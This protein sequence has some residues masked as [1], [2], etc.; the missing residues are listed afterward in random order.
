MT[1]KQQILN[2]KPTHDM[3]LPEANAFDFA[4]R[5]AAEIAAEADAEIA[6]LKS[7]LELTKNLVEKTMTLCQRMANKVAL[8]ADIL[9]QSRDE[10]NAA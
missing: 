4:T 2:L 1:Y 8:D 5:E 3:T 10:P 6:R 7:E 9:S